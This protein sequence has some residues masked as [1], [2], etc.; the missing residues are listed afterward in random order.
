MKTSPEINELA[1]A[2][3]L[4]QGSIKTPDKNKTAKIPTKD[5]RQYQYNYADLSQI[6]ECARKAL[7]EN[8]LAHIFTINSTEGSDAVLILTLVHSSGQWISS[9]M[10]IPEANDMKQMGAHLTYLRRYMLASMIDVHADEDTDSTP[11]TGDSTYTNRDKSSDAPQSPMAKPLPVGVKMVTPA[12]V[13]RLWA[14]MG[15]CLLTKEQVGA[16]AK[17]TFNVDSANDLTMDAYGQLVT[18]MESG[19]IK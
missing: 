6:V 10:Y 9:E 12:Q 7:S 11:E 13:K 4:A 19:A 5:G 14:I 16:Y 2:L 15:S 8:G 3:S 17:A 18:A 1:K